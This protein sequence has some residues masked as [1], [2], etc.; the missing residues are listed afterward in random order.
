M[1]LEDLK[2]AYPPVSEEG[3]A[4][5]LRTLNGLKEEEP[6]KRKLTL[7]LALA[8]ALILALMATGIALVATYSVK[9]HL[10]PKF[11]DQVTEIGDTYEN[12][13]LKLSLN[14]AI[15][16][17]SRM[18]VALN[19]AHKT[20]AGEV[21][22]F[23]VITAES[24]GQK[25]DVD[26]ESGFEFFDGAWLPEKT[27]N[28]A[29][30]GNH[31]ADF[32]IME[33]V[34]PGAKGDITWTLTFHV[35][36]PNWPLEVDP[37]SVKGYFE[38]DKIAHEEYEQLFRDAYK[39]KRILLTYGDATVEYCAYLPTPEGMDQ[40]KFL[41]M[42]EWERLVISGAFDEVDRFSRSFTTK[43]AERA[44]AQT[45]DNVYSFPEYDLTVTNLVATRMNMDATF[46]I[47]LKK[48]D[49]LSEGKRLFFDARAGG[50]TIQYSGLSSGMP[51]ETKDGNYAFSGVFDMT[52]LDALPDEI[53][54]VPYIRKIIPT[55]PGEN[56][57]ME[58]T[59][60]EANAFTVKLGQ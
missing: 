14:D 50:T 27:E 43:K 1:K 16:D 39:N 57:I 29:G 24:E 15:S 18:S 21:Y 59:Y 45:T 12:N 20:G 2:G 7:S 6:M 28:P 30:P 3:H 55:T 58:Y 56:P 31:T 42:P 33:D 9:D 48:A 13:W 37:Y 47:I 60:L 40:D 38:S 35:L 4:L 25:L 17:G 53:T 23:P 19:L 36:K 54:F 22:V 8:I 32:Y 10:N 5:F 11:A 41:W 34:L 51:N 49:L 26:L 46:S 52:S 44:E